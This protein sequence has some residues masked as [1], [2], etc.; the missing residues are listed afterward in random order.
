LLTVTDGRT[1]TDPIG[2]VD[3]FVADFDAIL[4]RSDDSWLRRLSAVVNSIMVQW[5]RVHCG[6]SQI[7][8]PPV[9]PS[10]NSLE[11]ILERIPTEP[12]SEKNYPPFPVP[13]LPLDQWIHTEAKCQPTV[14]EE[15]FTVTEII[16][17]HKILAE[18]KGMISN[19]NLAKA[20]E[21]GEK[22]GQVTTTVIQEAIN[23][24]PSNPIAPSPKITPIFDSAVTPA[25]MY[26]PTLDDAEFAFISG[27]TATK[28][29]IAFAYVKE[30]LNGWV[31]WYDV[32][33]R[34]IQHWQR[35]IKDLKE[36]EKQLKERRENGL[37]MLKLFVGQ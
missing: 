31:Y 10:R 34:Q 1:E 26:A 30:E 7:G 29:Q 15:D 4:A 19:Q 32:C 20:V 13:D 22:V 28:I 18:G 21:I 35:Q 11:L 5:I 16:R 17:E 33:G 24:L 6:F 36:A 25:K 27:N 23:L 2:L 37:K 12:T 8:R 3:W 14:I 9:D